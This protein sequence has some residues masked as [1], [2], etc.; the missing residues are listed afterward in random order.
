MSTVSEY[1][2]ETLVRAS[3]LRLARHV[4]VNPQEMKAKEM[5]FP[6]DDPYDKYQTP[7]PLPTDTSWVTQYTQH[8]A[9]KPACHDIPLQN[10]NAFAVNG[11]LDPR[12]KPLH[13][14]QQHRHPAS[15]Q[16]PQRV[17]A[18]VVPPPR[19]STD[20]NNS[21]SA[22]ANVRQQTDT[23]PPLDYPL[24]LLSLAE[25]Y[26]AAAYSHGS[27]SDVLRSGAESQIYYKLIATGLGCLEA[28]LKRFKLTPAREATV[29]LRYATILYEETE[30]TT[31]AEEALSK[32]IAI[33]DRHRLLD[34]RYN[35]Q[36]LL[37]RIL[38]QTNTRAAFKF[39]DGIMKDAEVYQ[40]IAWVY[41]LRFLKVS[42]HLELSTHQ[43]TSAA[44]TQLRSIVAMSNDYGD[45]AV[46]AVASTFEALTC[47]RQSSDAE[48]LELAQR[49]LASVRGL[50]LE[51]AVE[52]LP[53][54]AVLTSFVDLCC[55]L[56]YFDP[57]QVWP[58]LQIM[59]NAVKSIDE[60]QTWSNDGSFA[61]PIST[62]QML[63]CNSDEGVI[64]KIQNGSL[65]L[66]FNWIPKEDV[67]TI[68]FFLS[69]VAMAHRNT[70]D[71]QK[72]EKMLHEGIQRQTS[73]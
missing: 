12:C 5:A 68:G 44:L 30:N 1:K 34:L 52:G 70:T 64:R 9:T 25:E 31:E 58:K 59:Q 35:M 2:R 14:T 17:N 62:S 22:K 38:F 19:P 32:G 46:L 16:T 40:H 54:L 60:G 42:L 56:Q 37:T 23:V 72:S 27:L 10:E 6:V 67:C 43:D 41:A 53:Q 29:R 47:L 39:L 63:S 15:Y 33:C 55:H 49:A 36:H 65:A 13:V 11:Q 26:F 3:S 45:K 50:Q 4:Q 21:H 28:V 73:E 69:A 48:S 71:G 51:P 18:V 24:L 7:L 66:M 61:I 57:T 20:S 8:P